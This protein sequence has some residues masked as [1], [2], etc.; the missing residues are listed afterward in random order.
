M[1]CASLG[2]G[3]GGLDASTPSRDFEEISSACRYPKELL[4]AVGCTTFLLLICDVENCC[5][6]GKNAPMKTLD[7]MRAP[8][9]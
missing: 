5:P 6:D 2:D 9:Q 1:C 3:A 4:F 8:K 7:Q